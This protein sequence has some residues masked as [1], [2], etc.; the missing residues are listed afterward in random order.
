[1]KN[2]ILVVIDTNILVSALWSKQGNPAKIAHMIP[3]DKIIP[4]FCEEILNEYRTVLFRA[5]FDFSPDE[6][7]ELL[8]QLV[9]HGKNIKAVKS[10]I[11]IPDENDRIFYDVAKTVNAIL[12]TGNIKHYP[13]DPH[14]LTPAQFIE[15]AKSQ[16]FSS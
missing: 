10:D 14:I 1:M 8:T 6:I 15:Q 16:I 2:A 7:N 9:K 5:R 4:C 13:V 12:I 3:D 11:S